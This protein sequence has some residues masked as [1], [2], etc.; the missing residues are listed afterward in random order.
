[1]RQDREQMV[2]SL[3]ASSIYLDIPR[4]LFFIR[5]HGNEP[6][7]LRE[8]IAAEMT[9]WAF[10]VYCAHASLIDPRSLRGKLKAGFDRLETIAERFR[11]TRCKR[12]GVK[13]IPTPRTMISFDKMGL[14][15]D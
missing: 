3:L 9:I 8:V 6:T 14:G 13:L 12:K 15:R 5:S 1:M 10:C 2:T 11:R 7:K 4:S